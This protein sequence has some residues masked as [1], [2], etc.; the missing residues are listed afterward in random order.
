MAAREQSF[1]APPST[2][3]N[4]TIPMLRL[5]KHM[6]GNFNSAED[7]RVKSRKDYSQV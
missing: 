3:N 5:N 2:T 4:Q 1:I 7:L 6:K